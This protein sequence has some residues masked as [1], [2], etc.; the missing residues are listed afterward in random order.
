VLGELKGWGR[1]CHAE[2]NRKDFTSRHF[3]M[4]FNK[5]KNGEKSQSFQDKSTHIKRKQ[6]PWCQ[7]R[8][9]GPQGISPDCQKDSRTLILPSY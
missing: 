2:T 1:A 6:E 9:T 7:E 4:K 5:V 3:V 8:T